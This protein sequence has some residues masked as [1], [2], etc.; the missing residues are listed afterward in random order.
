MIFYDRENEQSLLMESLLKS[1][2]ESQM[3]VIMGRRRIGKTELAKRIKDNTILYFFVARKTEGLL[4]SDFAREAEEKLGIP[5][6]RYDTFAELFRY[7]LRISEQR[8]FTLIIDEFQEFIRVNSSIFSEVQ[9][10]WDMAKGKGHVNLVISGSVFP[11]MKKIFEDGREPLFGRANKQ[12]MLKP[13]S[14]DILKQI[15]SDHNPEYS[16]EDLLALFSVTGGIAWYVSMLMDNGRT[17]KRKILSYLTADNSPFINEGRNI[18]IEEFGTD[19][20][21]HFSIMTCI[22]G[23]L[24]TRSEIENIIRTD[25]IGSYLVRL[26]KYYGLIEKRLPIFTKENSK[27]VRY[28]L[29]DNFLTL[30]FRFFYKYQSF[31]EN[32]ALRQLARIIERDYNTLAGVMLERYFERKL[33]ETQRFTRMGQFWDRK[34]ENEIDLIAVN[35]I[36]GYA[37]IYEIKLQERKYEEKKLEEKVKVLLQNCEEMRGMD[38]RLGT[39]SVKDM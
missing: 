2:Q 24:K 36:D 11:L 9:R 31:V 22:A 30:W 28:A 5:V 20:A 35:E 21:V 39:L 38:I 13:F 37:E 29:S 32:D 23:G 26:E 17:T 14:T 19:Y 16:Q 15:L 3:T 7:L 10:E 12:I 18:L 8:P 27:K 33:R 34:G 6:G 25:N 4:C 1:R